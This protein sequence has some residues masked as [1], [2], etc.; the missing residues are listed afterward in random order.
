MFHRKELDSL[1]I[2]ELPAPYNFEKLARILNRHKREKKCRYLIPLTDFDED[3]I[4]APDWV[5][6]D[7]AQMVSTYLSKM[8]IDN[9]VK[10]TY[11][12]YLL[13]G[14]KY[15]MDKKAVLR[16]PYKNYSEYVSTI[17]KINELVSSSGM[18][19]VFVNNH[20]YELEASIVIHTSE[21]YEEILKIAERS[22]MS[23]ISDQGLEEKIEEMSY[24]YK[25]MFPIPPHASEELILALFGFGFSFPSL[26]EEQEKGIIKSK[27]TKKK[28]FISY[29]HKD[30][31][32]VHHIVDQLKSF[33]LNVWIDE[34]EIDYGDNIIEK[35]SMGLAECD[36]AL[37][38]LSNHTHEAKGARHELNALFSKIIYQESLKSWILV[39]LDEVDPNKIYFGLGNYK[40]FD[41]Q[42]GSEELLYTIVDK[43]LKKLADD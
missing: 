1:S 4:D 43:K 9:V 25:T 3:L 22:N 28:V 15:R 7:I 24:G 32:Q 21:N 33:G 17:M 8:A 14:E 10:Y 40:Y 30:K 18:L 34:Q 42:F 13:V 39:R 26:K 12:N 20:V 27:K 5:K 23:L 2:N 29:C 38:F 19:E 41:H 37:V 31:K 6:N 36:L 16:F 11:N 35:V